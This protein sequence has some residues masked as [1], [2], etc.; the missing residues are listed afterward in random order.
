[1]SNLDRLDL[2]AGITPTALDP[3]SD[4]QRA[5]TVAAA[6]RNLIFK[7]GELADE[8]AAWYDRRSTPDG[9][10]PAAGTW[11]AVERPIVLVSQE[12]R[13]PL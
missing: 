5:R 8:T 3:M 12:G 2:K 7:H 13:L 6:A 10:P 4:H 1:M 11:A 9:N